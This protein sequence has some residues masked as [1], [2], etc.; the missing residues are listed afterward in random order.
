MPPPMSYSQLVTPTSCNSISA[1][2]DDAWLLCNDRLQLNF[3]LRLS[4]FSIVLSVSNIYFC[5]N[6]IFYY[7][8]SYE[9]NTRA[10]IHHNSVIL[11]IKIIFISLV[12]W[13]AS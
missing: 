6:K 8:E 9:N 11:T 1:Y 4:Y 13:C 3:Y 7:H 12:L 5:I 2:K 10:I